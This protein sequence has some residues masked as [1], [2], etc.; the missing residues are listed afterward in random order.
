MK[1]LN[2]NPN[3]NGAYSPIQITS[4]VKC[5]EHEVIVP[6]SM[7]VTVFYEYSGFVILTIEN[8]TV[9]AMTANVEAYDTWQ[10]YLN[11][12]PEEPE[13]EPE[14]TDTEVLNTLLGVN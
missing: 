5:F 7:D 8:D 3:E 6:D 12:L 10:E 1:F 4:R 13:Q 9:T 2:R 14:P 11:S